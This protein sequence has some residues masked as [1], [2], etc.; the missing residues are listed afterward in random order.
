MDQYLYLGT[1]YYLTSVYLC[2]IGTHHIFYHIFLIHITKYA[3]QGLRRVYNDKQV[4][5]MT[6]IVVAHRFIDL[7]VLHEVD[8]RAHD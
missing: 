1:L 4:L 2:R 3:Y 6:D 7:Y 8:E 5:E